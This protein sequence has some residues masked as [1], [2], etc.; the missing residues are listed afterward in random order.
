MQVG[1]PPAALFEFLPA[2]AGADFVTPHLWLHGLSDRAL[3]DCDPEWHPVSMD[4]H[5][6]VGYLIGEFVTL[7][8]GLDQ[9]KLVRT[10]LVLHQ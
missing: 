6:G 1:G 7:G 5:N 9:F 4:S 8:R 10:E 3:V 2:P